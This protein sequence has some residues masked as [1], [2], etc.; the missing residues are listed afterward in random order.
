[1]SHTQPT[2]G[3]SSSSSPPNF[4]LIINNALE[5]YKKRTGKGLLAHPLAV[6]LQSCESPTAILAVLQ[7]QAQGIDPSR[8]TD[9][10][11]TKWLDPTVNVLC[12]FSNTLGAGISPVCFRTYTFPR[13]AIS[14]IWQVFSPASAIFAG[15]GVLLS[16]RILVNFA[17][18]ILT[19]RYFRQLKTFEQA[20]TLLL[21]SLSEWK[22]FSDVSRSTRK[23]HRQRGC[24]I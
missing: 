5:T 21:T 22:C 11:W 3:S 23:C 19:Y 24:W 9:D 1:M 10:R 8:S 14:F 7:Q 13:S 2:A 6:Q 20:T 18:A 12:T 16:V 4:Q 15:V 17:W